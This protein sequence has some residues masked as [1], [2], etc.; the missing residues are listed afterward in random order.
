VNTC[1]I[2]AKAGT[3][4]GIRIRLDAASDRNAYFNLSTGAEISHTGI[5]LTATDL[6]G[7]WYRLA[8][9]ADVTTGINYR[10]YAVDAT[11]TSTTGNI[12]VQDSQLEQGLVATDYIETT[13]AAVYEGITDNIP[14]INYE[15]GIGS[16]LLEPQ[17]TNLIPHSEYFN[18]WALDGDGAGQSVTANYSTSPEGVQN[19]YR[20]Q[21]S[22]SG[23]T[24]SRIRKS[25]IGSYSGDGVFSVYLKT[26]DSSTKTILMRWGGSGSIEKTITGDWQ[27]FDI[28][29]TS[30]SGLA[31]DCEIF[32]DTT[33]STTSV[34]LSIYGAQLEEGYLTSYI[35]TY[36]TSVTFASESCNNAGDSS[37]FNDSEGVLYAEIAAL[38]NESDTKRITLSDGT[39]SNRI[40]MLF[41]NNSIGMV[42]V[43]AGSVNINTILS[44]YDTTSIHKISLKYKTN[45]FA[46]WING[47]QVFTDTSGN[48]YGSD[49]LDRIS[50]DNGFGGNNFYGKTKMVSTFTEALSDSELECLTSWSSFNRM[51][52]AQNYTI[53]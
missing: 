14:R 48:A 20:L 19:A 39:S 51:A 8:F 43:S 30:V 7:G 2:H 16:F 27:R 11:G 24:Y 46:L 29:G 4:V 6:G 3:A 53:E 26:N 23:G 28:Q 32:L 45:D 35:P 18:D 44:G 22:K 17:R 52:T 21:L 37:L 12:F 1:S 47:F 13:T 25:I 50:F 10:I 31:I 41:G 36:G 33:I 38:V 40:T 49:V 15:N 5:S 9:A 42:Q 34:D